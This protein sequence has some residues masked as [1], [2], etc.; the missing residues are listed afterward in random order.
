MTAVV[1]AVVVVLLAAAPALGQASP[2][3]APIT[4]EELEQ[5]ALQNNPTTSA[6]TAAVAAARGRTQQA[7]AWPNPVIGYSGAE[8]TSNRDPRGEHGVFVEQTIPLGGKLRL[9]RD[10]FQK[11]TA[12]AEAVRD[13]QQ[14]RILGS[15]RQAFYTVLLTER[16]IQVQE[17]L[18]A[19]ASEAVGVTAQLFNVGSADR[20]DF[21]EMEIDSRRLELQ[22]ARSRNELRAARARLAAVTGVRDVADRPLAAAIDTAVPELERDTVIQG[23][24]DGSLEIR[25]ARAELERT[26]AVSAR[27][28]RATFPDLFLRGGVAYNREHGEESGRPV[29]WEGAIQAGISVPLFDRNAGGVATARADEARAQAELQRLELS[30]RARAEAEFSRYDSAV[31]SANAYRTEMLP[32]A[33]EAYKLYLSRY[34]EMAAAYPQVLVSQRTLF[35]LSAEYLEHLRQAWQSA[36]RLQSSL[37]GDGLSGPGLTPVGDYD[38]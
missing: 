16:R 31:Q 25:A 11:T 26:K 21:L 24:L 29:G 6:A 19:L 18:T 20:P 15:V 22:L 7:A 3:A 2:G 34:R 8:L 27:A 33:E 35:E 17:R 23:L 14:L 13:L 38:F 36:M 32:R 4:L 1:P 10:V 30:L 28:Q 12:Q 9:S 37:A 5:L